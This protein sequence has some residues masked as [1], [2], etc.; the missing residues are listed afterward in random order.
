MGGFK[1]TGS[2]KG[3]WYFGRESLKGQKVSDQGL[4]QKT[5]GMRVSG[6]RLWLQGNEKTQ[7]E[8]GAKRGR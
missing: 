4:Q 6:K 5:N 2:N 1:G 8:S 3:I 7:R